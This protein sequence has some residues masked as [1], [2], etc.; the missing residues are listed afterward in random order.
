MAIAS[1]RG[2]EEIFDACRIGH[3]GHTDNPKI[4][5]GLR[6]LNSVPSLKMAWMGSR[7]QVLR[8]RTSVSILAKA[9]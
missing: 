2:L 4:I 7:G 1:V 3:I 6:R 8:R 9:G 5:A